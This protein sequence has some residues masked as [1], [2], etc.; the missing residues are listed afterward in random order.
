MKQKI[1]SIICGVI[2]CLMIFYSYINNEDPKVNAGSP[3]EIEEVEE[4]EDE[5]VVGETEQ[6]LKYV[7][8]KGAVNNPGVYTFS[9]E[10]RVFEIFE[11]AGGLAEGANVEYI[12]QTR[13]V[14]DQMLIY[15]MTNNQIS[16]LIEQKEIEKREASEIVVATPKT[17]VI[18]GDECKLNNEPNN[19]SNNS[20]AKV[21]INNA[22]VAQ[23]QTLSGIGEAKA[24]EIIKY[25]NEHGGFSSLEELLNVNG[26]G[27]ATFNSIKDYISL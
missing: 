11:K 17:T 24:N 10:T 3:G 20:N 21:S 14:E 6:V 9:D 27:E 15:V 25:R 13:I 18:G 5:E 23:L 12:N 2:V 16:E 4:K 26:I 8:V 7:E 22:T 1:V 19:S